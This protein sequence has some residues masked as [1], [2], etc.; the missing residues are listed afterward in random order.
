MTVI[1][2]II[3]IILNPWFLL[4]L[5]FWILVLLA[6]FL[7]RKKKGAYTLFFPLLAMFKTKRLNRMILRIAKYK[8]K[9]WRIF[10]NVG[11][12]VSFGFM[13]YGFYFFFSNVVNLLFV[14]S[15]QNA[16]VP[17]I[18]GVTVSLPTLFY[19]ILPI[20][21][22]LTTHE[23]AHGISAAIDGVE[24]KST[25]VLGL[26][27]FYLIG[28]GAFV[29]VDERM[30]NSQKF[31]RNTRLRIAAAGT[32]VN[33]IV[34]GIALILLLSFPLLVSPFYSQV[35]Q[36][37]NVLKPEDGGF[38]YG[39]IDNGDAIIAIK[40]AGTPD[41]TY[42]FL[43][44]NQGV[45]LGSILNNETSIKC[46]VGDNLTLKTYNPNTDR[47]IDKNITLG[48]RYDIGLSYEY[49][50]NTELHLTYNFTSSQQINILITKINDTSINRTSGNT[51]E[52][53]FLNFNLKAL[54]LTTNTGISYLIDAEVIGVFVGVQTTLY[55]MYKN[56]FAKFFTASWPDFWLK[57]L[58]WLFVIGFSLT[59]FNMMPI[60]IFDGDRILKELVNYVFGFSFTTKRIKEDRF[61]FEKEDT[62]C[63][64]SEYRV[65]AIESIKIH[66]EPKSKSHEENF[67]T[68]SKENYTLID[69]TGDGFNDAVNIRLPP[70]HKIQ[71]GS[72]VRISY[73]YFDD[74]KKKKK[75]LISNTI[76]IIAIALIL[77]NFVLSFI[78]FGFYFPWLQ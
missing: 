27:V 11:I 33:A 6:V 30:L 56:D 67:I 21:F 46:S 45:I 69:S 50:S 7:L 9:F 49:K 31:K 58:S 10:W 72:P 38:N 54:N 55:W 16:I 44:Q 35:S 20:L 2:L 24:I 59:L 3:D 57:E 52:S 70:D 37:S 62:T 13:I 74:E 61:R 68:L 25:G 41:S 17:L 66:L 75:N 60:P 18:P 34:T 8:P 47:I 39:R 73:Q 63:K 14:P 12:F 48:P 65:E 26:G 22:L 36:V 4:S 51:L 28:F 32:Y 78:K 40:Q 42:V 64:L 76:R 29:E 19:L 71:D 15:I 5:L 1:D 77:G 23:F 53:F 43:D